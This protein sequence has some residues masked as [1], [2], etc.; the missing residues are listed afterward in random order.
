MAVT[1]IGACWGL[2]EGF[3]ALTDDVLPGPV[4]GL[5][6]L[7]ALLVARPGLQDDVAPVAGV[8]IRALPL[9]FVPA[10][11]AIGAVTGDVDVAALVVAMVVSV[12]VGFVVTARLAR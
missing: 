8:M 11:V 12:P 10:V 5:L 6:L 9:L 1:L 2:G 3:A 4:A 7:A